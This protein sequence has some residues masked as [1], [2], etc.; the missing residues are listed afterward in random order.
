MKKM[1]LFIFISGCGAMDVEKSFQIPTKCVLEQD[2]WQVVSKQVDVKDVTTTSILKNGCTLLN[3][4]HYFIP[5]QGNG[6]GNL[7]LAYYQRGC[8]FDGCGNPFNRPL[9]EQAINLV[10]FVDGVN[11][12]R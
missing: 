3:T 5:L 11:D 10:K 1:A 4:I 9:V 8:G 12:K 7:P 2:A 6:E